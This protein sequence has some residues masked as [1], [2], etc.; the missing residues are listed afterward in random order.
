MWGGE[1]EKE[2]RTCSRV[3]GALVFVKLCDTANYCND[4]CEVLPTTVYP[5]PPIQRRETLEEK[6]F[7]Q[8]RSAAINA[9]TTMHRTALPATT[10]RGLI[11]STVRILLCQKLAVRGTGP[12]VN[13]IRKS[14]G[15][16]PLLSF[17]DGTTTSI[18][19]I[20]HC[21]QR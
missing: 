15:G 1:E 12:N 14:C 11:A 10:V 20:N 8:S 17:P 13:S 18:S 6:S 19:D 9:S 21:V 4:I 5:T 7:L 16:D 2:R 3:N